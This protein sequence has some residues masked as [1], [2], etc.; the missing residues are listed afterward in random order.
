MR[1]KT[2]V[3]GALQK[4]LA[5]Q[6]DLLRKLA[7]KTLVQRAIEKAGELGVNG[8]AIYVYTDSEM[9]AL[10]AERAGVSAY[11]DPKLHLAERASVE[12][13]FE[14]LQQ[15][16][17]KTDWIFHLSPYAPLLKVEVLLEAQ[18]RIESEKA[19]VVTGV[20]PIV[21]YQTGVDSENLMTQFF[22][23][24]LKKVKA[25]SD[26]FTLIRASS[27]KREV[28]D[29]LKIITVSLDENEFEVRSQRDW[30]VCEKLLERKRIIFRVIGTDAVGMGHIYRSLSLAHEITDHEIFFVTD[31]KNQAAVDELAKYEYQL[32]VYEPDL[33][34][35][36]IAAL[37]P[38]LVINDI[39]NTELRDVQFLQKGGARVINFEDLGEGARLANITFNELYD[40]PQY[41]GENTRWGHQYFFV[42]DEFNDAKPCP[43]RSEVSGI[44]L[45]FGGIDQHDLTRKILFSIVD[46]CSARGIHIFVVTGPGYSGFKKLAKEVQNL[47]NVTITHATG[48]IS[49]YMEKVSLAITSNGR[50]VYEMAHMNIPAIVIPQHDRERTHAFA[51]EQNGFIPLA[52]YTEGATEEKAAT[53]LKRLLDSVSERK[54]LYNRTVDFRF[55]QNKKHVVQL[56]ESC[57]DR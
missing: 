43:F 36:E 16:S 34:L 28:T 17:L 6:D 29:K 44:L 9:V 14:F 21:D 22:R 25:H 50:T 42:R 2:I 4:H 10:S 31:T 48:V 57:L 11:L 49:Q 35:A 32:K 15:L 45:A 41:R 26:A 13:F 56:I 47:G 18:R 19:D 20:R 39:L 30:W 46:L 40:K 51:C 8:Q 38:D 7:G 3:I 54:K 1:S 52:P 5:F 55:D 23:T 24:P 33:L 53:S 27:L 37:K 12:K